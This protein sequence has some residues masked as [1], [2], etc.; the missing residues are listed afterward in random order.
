MKKTEKFDF[1]N[2]RWAKRAQ[3][4]NHIKCFHCDEYEIEDTA[5]RYEDAIKEAIVHLEEYQRSWYSIK[6]REIAIAYIIDE[7]L[8]HAIE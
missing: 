2:L 1:N 3:E 6:P 7:I 8:K 4:Q 5:N